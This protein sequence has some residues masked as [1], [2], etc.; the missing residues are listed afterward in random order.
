MRKLSDVLSIVSSVCIVLI[1]IFLVLHSY[2]DLFSNKEDKQ[3][4]EE[5]RGTSEDEMDVAR[6]KL[7]EKWA[8]VGLTNVDTV[9]KEGEEII[10]SEKESTAALIDIASKA[11][12]SANFVDYILEEYKDFYNDNYKYEFIR[13]IIAVPHDKYVRISNKLKDIR[14]KAYLKIAELKEQEGDIGGAF[15]YY[16]DAY[17]LSRFD[18]YTDNDHGVRYTAEQAMK[19]LLGIEGIESYKSWQ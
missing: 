18:G 1:L 10:G 15:F 4:V 5:V 12:K 8:S 7:I 13:D 9:I 2:P 19:R 11:N 3:E 17:R 6:Q 16:R 14:N